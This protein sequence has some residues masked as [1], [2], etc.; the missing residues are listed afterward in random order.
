MG[1]YRQ[2]LVDARNLGSSLGDRLNL[3]P[4][5]DVRGETIRTEAAP[6]SVG[7]NS[8]PRDGQLAAETWA[9]NDPEQPLIASFVYEKRSPTSVYRHAV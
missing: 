5:C 1:S 6:I 9:G 2:L 4:K 7:P 3:R 8:T